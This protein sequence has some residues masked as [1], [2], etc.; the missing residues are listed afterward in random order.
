MRKSRLLKTLNE[1]GWIPKLI[2]DLRLLA[3]S[4]LAA[5]M[6]P[7]TRKDL[8]SILSKNSTE[9][10]SPVRQLPHLT[11]DDKAKIRALG[12]T[13]DLRRP[14]YV[15][16]RALKPRNNEMRETGVPELTVLQDA[17]VLNKKLGWQ[18]GP[19]DDQI[20]RGWNFKASKPNRKHLA[21][22]IRLGLITR[23]KKA[24]LTRLVMSELGR[25]LFI[26]I[27][28]DVQTPFD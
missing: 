8:D 22:L 11:S 1:P 5:S 24:G 13:K 9:K 7:N 16:L 6:D 15:I 18:K 14:Y 20:K 12:E 2:A 21:K 3:S 19:T 4:K 28:V 27:L 17:S 23:S 26:W 25:K 10:L